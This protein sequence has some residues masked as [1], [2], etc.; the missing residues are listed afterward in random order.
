M[1]EAF[2]GMPGEFVELANTIEGFGQL[3]EGAGDDYPEAAFYMTGDIKKAFEK[4][5]EIER[6]AMEHAN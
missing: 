5:R 4:G 1:A 6:K 3:L 2:S